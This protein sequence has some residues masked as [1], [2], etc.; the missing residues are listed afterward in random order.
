MPISIKPFTAIS[1]Y[2][3]RLNGGDG[4]DRIYGIYGRDQ[5]SGGYGND[6]IHGGY[7]DDELYGN[8]AMISST[9]NLVT[10]DSS[11]VLAMT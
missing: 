9:E 10:T 3:D 7:D 11:V 2:N 5:L 8:E 1:Y 6:R 4:D